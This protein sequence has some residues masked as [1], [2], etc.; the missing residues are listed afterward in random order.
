M[1]NLSLIC[2][3]LF[4]WQFALAQV[5]RYSNPLQENDPIDNESPN[6]LVGFLHNNIIIGK[7]NEV[8]GFYL[9][10]YNQKLGL[11]NNVIYK[12]LDLTR[13][14]IIDIL[15]LNDVGLLYIHRKSEE[16]RAAVIYGIT[17]SDTGVPIREAEVLDSLPVSW[18]NFDKKFLVKISSNRRYALSISYVKGV[19]GYWLRG[20]LLNGDGTILQRYQWSIPLENNRFSEREPQ[21]YIDNNGDSYF[22][23][24]ALN[25]QGFIEPYFFY[26]SA[27]NSE[28][29]QYP[30]DLDNLRISQIQLSLDDQHNRLFFYGIYENNKKTDSR[31]LYGVWWDKQQKTCY[32]RRAWRLDELVP[33][34]KSSQQN[35]LKLGPVVFLKNGGFV[36]YMD[37][38]VQSFKV[39]MPIP[40][41]GIGLS[42]GSL[43]FMKSNDKVSN[44]EN[45]YVFVID[46]DLSVK[47]KHTIYKHQQQNNNDNN[48]LGINT[49]NAGNL[50]YYLYNDFQ[51]SGDITLNSY[52]LDPKY[53]FVKKSLGMFANN[54]FVINL[55]K[56]KQIAPFAYLAPCIFKDKWRSFALIVL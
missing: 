12:E 18:N 43:T 6:Y 56:G 34:L 19:G 21:L 31:G 24:E 4:S 5:V 49:L 10:V 38:I 33:N 35:N 17:F 46:K 48:L 11:Q 30:I 3:F 42:L 52:V 45:A 41:I 13:F 44:A 40:S 54:N 20:V 23:L 47:A 51:N 15:N 14:D 26:L 50:L 29:T 2:L 36:S 7:I 16:G 32:S 28:I 1:R 22:M 37:E 9:S 27:Q 53:Q 55:S 39:N 8:N 25:E